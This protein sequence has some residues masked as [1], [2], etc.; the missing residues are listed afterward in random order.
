MQAALRDKGLLL[1]SEFIYFSS[2][3]HALSFL[4]SARVAEN[5]VHCFNRARKRQKERIV[6][7]RYSS[8]SPTTKSSRSAF[9]QTTTIVIV[10]AIKVIV[11]MMST[12]PAMSSASRSEERRVGKECR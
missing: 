4:S 1:Q 12:I 6:P 8:T 9:T 11:A 10:A 5:G 2:S 7:A 3:K